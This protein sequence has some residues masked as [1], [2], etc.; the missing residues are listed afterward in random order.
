M[1]SVR[2]FVYL[3][4][5]IDGGV[6]DE[7]FNRPLEW[8]VAFDAVDTPIQTTMWKKKREKNLN[9]II[10]HNDRVCRGEEFELDANIFDD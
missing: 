4:M 8:I 6:Q 9:T 5:L 7:P 3:S 2:V 10:F 1:L